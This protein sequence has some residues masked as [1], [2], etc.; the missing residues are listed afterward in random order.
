MGILTLL[1]KV[2]ILTLRKTVLELLLRKVGI[3]TKW[4]YLLLYEVGMETKLEY[5]IYCNLFHVVV[6]DVLQTYAV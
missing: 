3:G 4:E 1:R 2:G 5:C 6:F